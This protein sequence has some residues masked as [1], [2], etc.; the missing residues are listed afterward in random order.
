M[1][2]EVMLLLLIL[3]FLNTYLSVV[4]ETKID[5]VIESSLNK[6]NEVNVIVFLKE[7]NNTIDIKEKQ[8]KILSTISVDTDFKLKHKYETV[9][10]FSGNITKEGLKKLS[11]DPNVEK[12]IES[13]IYH[14]SLQEGLLLINATLVTG[15]K[16][17]NMPVRGSGQSICIIDTGINYGHESFGSCS[18]SS[19]LSGSC[20]KVLN[21]VNTIDMSN[22]I[23]IGI[24]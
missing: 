1:K 17:N 8:D 24:G 14:I 15:L 13:K 22:N 6:S 16:I 19:F 12:I 2:K 21:G 3:F 10:A 18:T 4:A 5:P 20:K 9:N 23:F 11:L 7:Q